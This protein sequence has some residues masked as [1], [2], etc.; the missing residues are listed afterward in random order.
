M[1]RAFIGLGSNLGDRVGNLQRAL[2]LLG[3]A[4]GV[5]VEE[6][7]SFIET[8]P[9]GG[10]AGQGRFINAAAELR[11]DLSPRRLLR[12]LLALE[13]RMGR[14]RTE[15]WGPRI[16]DLDLLL[17]D[18]SIIATEELV[19]PHPRMHERLFVLVPLAEIAGRVVHPILGRSIARLLAERREG[20]ARREAA[21][22]TNDVPPERRRT[23]E[24]G[25]TD[26]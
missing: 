11:T 20:A 16:I 9:V 3:A 26:K 6:V 8:D 23:G 14:R 10:P 21:D 24:G 22:A 19:V 5:S 4:E 12:L 15:R 1:A 17:Y 2:E 25:H 7:S 18:D 13:E